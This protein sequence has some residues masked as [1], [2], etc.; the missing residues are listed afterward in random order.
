MSSSIPYSTPHPPHFS[1]FPGSWSPSDSFAHPMAQACTQEQFFHPEK[2]NQI[3][4]IGMQLRNFISQCDSILI[5]L[6]SAYRTERLDT[7][8]SNWSLFGSLITD[9]SYEKNHAVASK[10]DDLRQHVWAINYSLQQMG[11][12]GLILDT[13]LDGHQIRSAEDAE[14]NVFANWF[15]SNAYSS[16]ASTHTMDQIAITADKVRRVRNQ[17]ENSLFFLQSLHRQGHLFNASKL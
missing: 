1:H 4:Q 10:I 9:A 16:Y 5:D 2:L 15:T 13:D 17:A 6:N 8:T 7:E 14:H 11:N 3:N 12:P